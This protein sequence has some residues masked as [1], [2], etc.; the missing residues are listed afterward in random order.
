MIR[1]L[2]LTTVLICA[3]QSAAASVC[4]T[5]LE[6]IDVQI[7]TETLGVA[8]AP[9]TRRERLVNLPGRSFGWITGDQRQC[10]SEEV[11]ALLSTIE[12][13][14]DMCLQEADADIGYLLVPG[15]RNYRG[16]CASGGVCTKVN[17]TKETLARVTGTMAGT[18]M[19]T[20]DSTLSKVT[21]SSGTV[22][23]SGSGAAIS[24]TLGTAATGAA[25]V[26]SA[27]VMLG[28]AA[29]TAV[30]VGGAVYVCSE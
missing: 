19:G 20:G 21:H 3:A 8:P 2:A 9:T 27:P 26:F 30:A 5:R 4:A 17:G 18:V 28:A 23:L 14:D 16:R 1:H 11:F 29:V 10:S 7:D 13:V 12:P 22:L 24:N 6:G 25:G 15:E